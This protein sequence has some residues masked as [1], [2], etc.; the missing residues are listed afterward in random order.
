MRGYRLVAKPCVGFRW[1]AVSPLRV[2]GACLPRHAM[3]ADA[4][5]HR[6]RVQVFRLW[7]T[8]LLGPA[9]LPLFVAVAILHHLRLAHVPLDF[10]VL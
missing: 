7:D 9:C 1:A 2:Y 5:S 4:A 3:P 8:L 10:E 6:F